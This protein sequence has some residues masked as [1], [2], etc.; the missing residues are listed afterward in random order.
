MLWHH[1]HRANILKTIMKPLCL[2]ILAL[3]MM[4]AVPRAGVCDGAIES[5]IGFLFAGMIFGVPSK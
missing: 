3:C 2:L 4:F 1:R 5:I